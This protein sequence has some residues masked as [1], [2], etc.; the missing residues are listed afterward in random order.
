MKRSL[1]LA[2]AALLVGGGVGA[3]LATWSSGAAGTASA[4]ATTLAAGATP[5]AAVAGRTVTLSWTATSFADGTAATS[6]T[7]RRYATATGGTAVTSL[8]CSST[9]CAETAVPPGTWHYGVAP[10]Y[11]PWTGAEGGRGSATVGAPSLALTPTSIGSLPGTLSGS[12]ADFIDGETLT[13]RLDDATTGT[14]LEATLNGTSTSGSPAPTVPAGG[15]AAVTVTVPA[16]TGAGGHTI[17]AVGSLEGSVTPASAAFTYAPAVAPSLTLNPTTVTSVTAA[18]TGSVTGFAPGENV[19]FRLDDAVT[20]TVL[21]TATT[22]A[23][24]AAGGVAMTLSC[25]TNGTRTVH[26]VSA[27]STASA[28]FTVAAFCPMSLG[29]HNKAGGIAG[30]VEAG[31]TIVVDYSEGLDTSTLCAGLA[32]GTV[33]GIT[34]RLTKGGAGTDNT[35]VLEGPTGTGNCASNVGTFALGSGGYNT[36]AAKAVSFT[37]STMAWDGA[38]KRLTVTLGTPCSPGG[39]CGT[40]ATVA[41]AT[42]ATHTP[43]AALKSGGTSVSGTASRSAVHF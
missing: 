19:S 2:V 33:S 42:T 20:G 13:F 14:V 5:A 24:G 41:T 17:Y 36:D 40:L 11:G 32:T 16:G 27:T 1:A 30:R 23:G 9:S 22:D 29:L 26:A 18:F 7:L 37:G 21:A 39:S 28:T 35:I 15:S 34:A 10:G 25:L 12:I 31:D 8:P 3:A 6:Y 4:R 38:A 43:G